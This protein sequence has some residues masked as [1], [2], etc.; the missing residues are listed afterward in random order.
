MGGCA[1]GCG[2]CATGQMGFKRHL[3]VGEIFEQ[4]ARFAFKL[5]REGKRLSSVVLMGMG[6][7]L[8]N[9]DNVISA[10]RRIQG[11]LGVGWRRITLSTVGR[12]PEIRRLADERLPITLAVSLHAATDEERSA[13]LPINKKW[14]ISTLMEAVRYYFDMTGR[15]VS[16]EWTLIAGK[17]DDEKT[18]RQLGELASREAP[19]SHINLIPL[20]PTQGFEGDPTQRQAAQRFVAT[21]SQFGIVATIRVRRGIDIDAGC[22]QLAE[23]ASADY[24]MFRE[25]KE[26][27]EGVI[28]GEFITDEPSGTVSLANVEQPA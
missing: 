3:T 13:L 20:N 14:P 17:N 9:Y 10:V 22:G 11:E 23:R 6:E 24:A 8:A 25:E 27:A 12:V 16:F 4:A 18:A 2:F 28:G 1:M 7:P 5:T 26:V 15:R 19:G 21:L